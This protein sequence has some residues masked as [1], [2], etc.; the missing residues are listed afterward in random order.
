MS[1]IFPAAAKV[2]KRTLK[3]LAI[4]LRASTS[5]CFLN[6]NIQNSTAALAQSHKQKAC[7]AFS[8]P[9]SHHRSTS[10]KGNLHP[11]FKT[12]QA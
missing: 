4:H 1:L 2:E 9:P 11:M 5:C 8:Q 10:A 12:Q 3:L 6:H 7:D